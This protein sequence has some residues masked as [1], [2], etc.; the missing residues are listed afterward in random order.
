MTDEAGLI[1][2][3]YRADWAR[4]RL[5]ARL[6]EGSTAAMGAGTVTL[7]SGSGS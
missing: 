3:L 2:L 1:G 6:S 4:L 7:V 5:S